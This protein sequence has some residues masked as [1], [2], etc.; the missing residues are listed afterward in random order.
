MAYWSGQ[1]G[2]TTHWHDPHLALPR[3]NDARAVGPYEARLRLLA[4]YLLDLHLQA[5]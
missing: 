5:V 1:Q 3:L 4:H 2:A